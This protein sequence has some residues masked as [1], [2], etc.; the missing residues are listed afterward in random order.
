MLM[1]P[2]RVKADL[3][4]KAEHPLDMDK[5]HNMADK[6]FIFVRMNSMMVKSFF[7]INFSRSNNLV[8]WFCEEKGTR[9][10]TKVLGG[11][12][13]NVMSDLS[14]HVS[15]SSVCRQNQ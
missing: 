4:A 12:T 3:E 15:Q 5:R 8:C 6:N 13:S 10:G 2:E 1:L 9:S 14:S 7:V 11:G